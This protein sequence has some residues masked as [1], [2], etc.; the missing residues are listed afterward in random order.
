MREDYVLIGHRGDMFLMMVMPVL[1]AM[2]SLFIRYRSR[3]TGIGLLIVLAIAAYAPTAESFIVLVGAAG[4]A[5]CAITAWR[6]SLGKA[7]W[8]YTA[9]AVV[10]PVGMLAICGMVYDDQTVV[11]TDDQVSIVNEV[12][13]VPL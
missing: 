9:V 2:L 8:G 1:I 5:A 7:R 11:L 13:P 6:R 4:M 10:V 12:Y 3:D